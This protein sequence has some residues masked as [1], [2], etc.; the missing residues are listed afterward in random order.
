VDCAKKRSVFEGKQGGQKG[1]NKPQEHLFLEASNI[2]HQCQLRLHVIGSTC[3]CK[4][5]HAAKVGQKTWWDSYPGLMWKKRPTSSTEI[6]YVSLIVYSSLSRIFLSFLPS[7]PLPLFKAAKNV[8]VPPSS[9]LRKGE[10][11]KE[12]LFYRVSFVLDVLHHS[13]IGFIFGS[14]FIDS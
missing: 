12:R 1:W 13:C 11:K 4:G 3:T 6:A 2:L 5:V 9:V 10:K 8:A 14:R 7:F